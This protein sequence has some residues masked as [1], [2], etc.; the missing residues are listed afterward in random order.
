MVRWDITVNPRSIMKIILYGNKLND[1]IY[2]FIE[3]NKLL[4]I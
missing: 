2:R 3:I 4:K 1:E